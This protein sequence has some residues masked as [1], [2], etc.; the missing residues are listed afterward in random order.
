MNR[1]WN[2]RGRIGPTGVAYAPKT[3]GYS[4]TT[5]LIEPGYLVH[6]RL[7]YEEKNSE[8]Y[9]WDLGFIQPLVSTAAFYK[10]AFLFPAHLASNLYERY[11]TSAGKC[12]PGSPVPYY[13]YPEEITPFGATVGALAIVGTAFVAP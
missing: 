11:D 9:G 10:D 4:P 8:R 6:R 7:F 1:S 5:A 3:A 13:L 2:A 12:L